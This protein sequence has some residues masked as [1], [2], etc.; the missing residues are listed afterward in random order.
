MDS[1]GLVSMIRNNKTAD[2]ML[3]YSI[4]SRRQKS[5]ELLKRSLGDYIVLEGFKLV[6]DEK[7]KNEEFVVRLI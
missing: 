5:F 3:L 7:L 2:L 6:H 4:F 1:S